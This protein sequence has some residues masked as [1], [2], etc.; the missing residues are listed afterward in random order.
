[1]TDWRTR[2][3]ESDPARDAAMSALDVQRVRSV[4][5]SAANETD[6]RVA[7]VWPR[8]FV[9]TAAVLM[10]VCVTVLTA[11][12]RAAGD[13]QAR[14]AAQYQV[15]QAATE[16][17]VQVERTQLQFTTPGGTRIIW[18]FDTQFDVKGTLP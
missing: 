4:I 14:E 15:D 7:F 6:R 12:H 17:G 10:L 8:A 11:L 16:D 18:V 13:T 5:L 9:A 3:R 1:M 2:L